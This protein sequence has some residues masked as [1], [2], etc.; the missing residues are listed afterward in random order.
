MARL[1][2]VVSGENPTL[3]Y[4]EVKSILS[5]EGFEYE[6]I[7]EQTQ[8]L[9]VEA[10]PKCVESIK[11]RSA[12]ARYC[13]LE[14]FACRADMDE[15]RLNVENVDFTRFLNDGESFVVR[16]LRVRGASPNLSCIA[17][18]RRIGGLI[19][20]SVKGRNIRVNL[21][22]PDKMFMGFLTD[23]IFIFGLKLAELTRKNLIERNPHKRVFFH[24]AA[25]TA[26]MARCM[27]N[28]AGA[29]RGELLLDP[30]CGT[31]SIL[32]E[33]G[34]IGCRVMGSDIKRYM[35]EGSIRNLTSYG[36]RP[37][38]MTVSDARFLPLAPESVDRI[39]TDPPYGTAATTLGLTVRD[40]IERFLSGA[41]EVIKRGGTVCLAAPST[42]SVSEIGKKCGFRHIESHYIY[43]HR[44]LTREIAVFEK[45]RGA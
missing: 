7:G 23:N 43:V 9:R 5:A 15:I 37:E 1:F 40:L 41:I 27:V 10:D 2:F 6:V 38:H 3:P 39:V 36:L 12:L 34:L 24:P 45:P 26:K 31:G 33:A 44:R 42:L 11:F 4:S 32:I 21:R 13:C 22:N 25:L 29:K 14:I 8:V 18:E 20:E 35:V 16:V 28:L 19:F 30:F 17:L